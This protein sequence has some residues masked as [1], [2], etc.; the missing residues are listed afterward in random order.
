MKRTNY[1]PMKAQIVVKQSQGIQVR[2]SWWPCKAKREKNYSHH[3]KDRSIEFLRGRKI[4]FLKDISQEVLYRFCG[5][6]FIL[7]NFLPAKI[8]IDF[9]VLFLLSTT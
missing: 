5:T 6:K 9:S 1:E 3:P 7:S 4:E 2:A 8:I